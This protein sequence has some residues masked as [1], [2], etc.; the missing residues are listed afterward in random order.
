MLLEAGICKRII[1]L[2]RL[3]NFQNKYRV[4]TVVI[5]AWVGRKKSIYAR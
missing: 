4:E 1:T 2:G 5:S 3:Q